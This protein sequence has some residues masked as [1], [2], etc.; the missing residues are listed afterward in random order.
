MGHIAIA[1][2]TFA[3]DL[4]FGE[5]LS[6]EENEVSGHGGWSRPRGA[7]PSLRGARS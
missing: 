4:A 6:D 3:A 7:V 1:L 5:A 2:P